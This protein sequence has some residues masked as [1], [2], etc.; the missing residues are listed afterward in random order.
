MFFHD[1]LLSLTRMFLRFPRSQTSSPATCPWVCSPAQP[2]WSSVHPRLSW[3]ESPLSCFLLWLCHIHSVNVFLSLAVP[4]LRASTFAWENRCPPPESPLAT[5]GVNR[6]QARSGLTKFGVRC[7]PCCANC[8]WAAISAQL[9][10][11]S[12][13]EASYKRHNFKSIPIYKQQSR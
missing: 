2:H 4:F 8:N 1:W 9:K 6:K 12:E 7:H 10:K 5:P 13:L 3:A 11:A